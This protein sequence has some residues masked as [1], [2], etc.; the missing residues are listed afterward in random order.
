M[1]DSPTTPSLTV[2]SA[3]RGGRPRAQVPRSAVTTWLPAPEHDKLVRAA[4]RRGV[5]VSAVLRG[6]VA[7]MPGS[8]RR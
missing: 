3:R 6:L 8:R 7:R 4:S 2:L 5:S 1:D